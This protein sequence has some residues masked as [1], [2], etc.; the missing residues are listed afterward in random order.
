MNEGGSKRPTTTW[1]HWL[2][3]RVC[4]IFRALKGFLSWVL[5][6]GVIGGLCWFFG[7]MMITSIRSCEEHEEAREA[8]AVQHNKFVVGHL[9]PLDKQEKGNTLGQ[10]LKHS[11]DRENVIMI[12]QLKENGSLVRLTKIQ[13]DQLYF[14]DTLIAKP[15]VKMTST[16]YARCLYEKDGVTMEMYLKEHA[17]RFGHHKGNRLN[18]AIYIYIN[19]NDVPKYLILDD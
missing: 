4:D 18:D 5:G 2:W 13:T 15:L 12:V 3:D 1:Y 16:E 14:V 11:D 10:F 8:W 6:L 17:T 19:R 9:V 7:G